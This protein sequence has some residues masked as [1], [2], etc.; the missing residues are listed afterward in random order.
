MSGKFP[1]TRHAVLA[2]PDLRFFRDLQKSKADEIERALEERFPH[3][4]ADF[5]FKLLPLSVGACL[6]I[7]GE[8]NPLNRR[9]HKYRRADRIDCEVLEFELLQLKVEDV[10]T[11]A[12]DLV[13]RWRAIPLGDQPQS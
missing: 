3:S 5:A 13:K 9:G 6:L 11:V 7:I 8:A 12:Q 10:L 4:S 1:K 2:N